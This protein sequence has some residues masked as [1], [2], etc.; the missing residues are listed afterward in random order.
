MNYLSFIIYQRFTLRRLRDTGGR[1][2]SAGTATRYGLDA[3][4]IESR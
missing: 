3:P 1:D 4:R 2:R